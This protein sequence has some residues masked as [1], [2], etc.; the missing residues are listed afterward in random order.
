MAE[1]WRTNNSELK[2]ILSLSDSLPNNANLQLLMFA[3]KGLPR[4]PAIFIIS[5][6]VVFGL[7]LR[8]SSPKP[9]ENG[10]HKIR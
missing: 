4:Y 3:T 7:V 10:S 5:T 8:S 6:V 9:I 1:L 2:N